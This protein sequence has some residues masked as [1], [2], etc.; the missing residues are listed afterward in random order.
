MT[1]D[2][3]WNRD[4]SIDLRD[5]CMYLLDNSTYDDEK[6]YQIELEIFK[7]EEYELLNLKFNLFLNQIDRISHGLNY[8]QTDIKRKLSDL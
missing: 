8:N 4:E 1:F 6:K 7:M 2:E 5:F 3:F